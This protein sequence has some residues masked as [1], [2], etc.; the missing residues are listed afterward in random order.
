MVTEIQEIGRNFL[1]SNYENYRLMLNYGQNNTP[2]LSLCSIQE[3]NNSYTSTNVLT[4]DLS[5]I[6]EQIGTW[7]RSKENGQDRQ[8]GTHSTAQTDK[9]AVK[10]F[11]SDENSRYT[12][13][14]GRD[15]DKMPALVLCEGEDKADLDMTDIFSQ[16]S[17]LINQ[18]EKY[19][20]MEWYKKW[21]LDYMLFSLAGAGNE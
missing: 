11:L 18:R 19:R 5:S 12:L 10:N 9:E 16:C 15:N 4:L 13:K 7:V 1:R 8:A 6:F 2:Y 14:L 20:L 17:Y 21:G 3:S